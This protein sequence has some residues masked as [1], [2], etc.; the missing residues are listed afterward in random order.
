MVSSDQPVSIC[1]WRRP[2]SLPAHGYI[3]RRRICANDH[4]CA[5]RHALHLR[6]DH[7]AA[8]HALVP[9]LQREIGKAPIKADARWPN[10]PAS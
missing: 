4:L 5:R 6:I 2:K 8:L 1:N 10:G 3:F 9:S 7:H